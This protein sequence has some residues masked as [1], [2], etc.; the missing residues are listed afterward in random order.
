M[1][2]LKKLEKAIPI[3]AS[4]L[5]GLAGASGLV[6]TLMQKVSAPEWACIAT[7]LVIFCLAAVFWAQVIHYRN[8]SEKFH[9]VKDVAGEALIEDVR[10]ATECILVTHF[11]TSPIGQSYASAMEQRCRAG[12][13]V[14]RIIRRG[15]C[16]GQE[17]DTWLDAFKTCAAYR[18]IEVD[19]E[20]PFDFIVFDHSKVQLWFPVSPK[21]GI[22]TKAIEFDNEDLARLFTTAFE[23]L[24]HPPALLLA[25]ADAARA[26]AST[27]KQPNDRNA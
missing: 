26:A 14:T 7:A 10:E 20:M 5:L 11:S 9:F 22:F 27:P 18:Q 4:E 25:A 23:R 2:K 19:L 21:A 3:G 17:H 15:R 12:L 6:Y 1:N 24:Q 8:A 13:P 16:N